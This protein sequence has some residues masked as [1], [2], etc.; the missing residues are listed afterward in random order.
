MVIFWKPEPRFS[1]RSS[2]VKTSAMMGLR[3]LDGTLAFVEVRGK[4]VEKHSSS[5]VILKRFSSKEI[6]FACIT[7]HFVD[8]THMV[9]P[10]YLEDHLEI[11]SIL[12]KNWDLEIFSILLTISN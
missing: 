5:P 1:I 7:F 6:S 12:L 11:F 10:R 8:D 3:R 2:W 4:K 9:S